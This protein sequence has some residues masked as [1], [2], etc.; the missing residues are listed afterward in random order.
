[1]PNFVHYIYLIPLLLS[2]IFSIK[3]FKNG[4]ALPY[5]LFSIFLMVTMLV[6]LFAI[7][8]KLSLHE[9][10]YW[11]YSQSNLWIYNIYLGPQYLFY[12]LFYSMA[13]DSKWLSKVR[14][15]VLISYAL[16]GVVNM[17]FIQSMAQLNTFTIVSGS[18][19]VLLGSLSY[20][21]Q[22]INRK[23]PLP[24]TKQPLFWIA[25][26]GFL[27]HTVSLP[28]FISINYLSRTNLPLAIVLFNI[29]LALNIFMYSFY[30]MAFLCKQPYLKKQL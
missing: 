25:L 10:A 26:G 20:F 24:V 18:A 29:L 8:W 21:A 27:F 1:M 5:R 11:S 9:T 6:E 2:I 15:P 22:E 30:L 19:L 14:Y 4:W 7:S 3:T 12:F 28:Y 17:F 23:E 16:F 13:L